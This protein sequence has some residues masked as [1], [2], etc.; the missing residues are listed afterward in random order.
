[1]ALDKRHRG[2]SE[3]EEHPLQGH[4][5]IRLPWPYPPLQEEEGSGKRNYA[6]LDVRS[7]SC[8]TNLTDVKWALVAPVLLASASTGL[9][10]A[11]R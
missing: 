11:G 3:A 1:M 9:P 6:L 7:R 5:V 2:Y 8:A 4:G 10:A